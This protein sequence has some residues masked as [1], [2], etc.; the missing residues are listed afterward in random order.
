MPYLST[1]SGVPEE[2][3]RVLAVLPSASLVVTNDGVVLRASSRA[4]ALGLVRNSA[5]TVA[6]LAQLADQVADDGEPREQEMRIRRPPLG[7]ELMEVRVRAAD[8]GNGTI[9]ILVDD[10][11]EDRRVDAVRRDFVANVSHELKTPV[12]AL[13]LLAEAVMSSA[14]D[15]DQ[16]RHFADRMQTEA[17]R[18]SHLIQDVIDLSRLQSDDP[19]THAE[20]VVADELIVRAIEELRTVAGAANIEL[21]RGDASDALIYGDRNQ[22]LTA[23]RNLVSNAVHYSPA[24]TRVALNCQVKQDLVEI[25]VT[26]QG[27][28]IAPSELDRIF[29]RFYR[30]DQARSRSS[31]GTGLGLAIVKHV[32]QNHGGECIVWSELGIGSTFTLRLPLYHPQAVQRPSSHELVVDEVVDVS[33]PGSN[34]LSEALLTSES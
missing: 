20:V 34:H 1:P 4:I 6:D 25:T 15:A 32:C 16:V 26:D 10:L 7:R 8:I 21:I 28:G 31:G 17:M 9:L 2:V 23:I 11:T 27:V 19:M 18:L 30:V 22:L 29:E 3:A 12:G 14:E 5:I 24:D 13:S 33:T